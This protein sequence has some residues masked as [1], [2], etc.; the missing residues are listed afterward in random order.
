LE[1]LSS[2]GIFHRDLALRNLLITSGENSSEISSKY[3]VKVADFGLAKIM[4]ENT[5]IYEVQKKFSVE[6]EFFFSLSPLLIFF[7]FVGAHQKL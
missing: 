5:L 1:Y 3:I 6:N 7:L 4:P 2:K